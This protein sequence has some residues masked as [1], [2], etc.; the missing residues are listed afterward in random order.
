MMESLL[1]EGP[2]DT[3]T[4]MIAGFV[5]IFGVMLLYLLSLGV[6]NRNLTQDLEVLQEIAP[7]MSPETNDRQ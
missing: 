6:R 2:A 1:L 4:Y 5:V 7:E 3:T